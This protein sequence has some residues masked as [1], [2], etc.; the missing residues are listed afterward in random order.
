MAAGFVVLRGGTSYCLFAVL[1]PVAA[2]AFFNNSLCII[3]YY[4]GVST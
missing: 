2:T 4:P 1:L 3:E